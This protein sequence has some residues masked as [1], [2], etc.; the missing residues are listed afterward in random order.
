[1]KKIGIKVF[2]AAAFMVALHSCE[3][4]KVIVNRE[5]NSKADGKMLLGTQSLDQLTK[6]PYS[7]WYHQEYDKYNTDS[8]ALAELKKKKLNSYQ[9]VAFM[10]TWCEDS[11]MYIPQLIKV[12][13]QLKY[14]KSKLTLIAVNRKY[15]SPA[16]EE[17]LYNIQKV[18]T[19]IIK[20]NGK[21]I[22]RM[23]EYPETGVLERD[24]VQI[25]NKDE[26]SIKNIFD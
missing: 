12:L 14:P 25:L 21:E 3:T 22:G 1:M 15:E 18:P 7:E 26:R 19:I 24:L 10:G 23:K 6:E 11:H 4:N 20:R 13:D 17:G 5:V 2:W 9:I 8:Q 16:G